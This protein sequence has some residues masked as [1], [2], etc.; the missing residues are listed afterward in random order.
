MND[1]SKRFDTWL[2][3]SLADSE[4]GGG[5]WTIARSIQKL[6]LDGKP[7]PVAG[8]AA[9]TGRSVEEVEQALE[10]M[11]SVEREPDGTVVGFGLSLRPTPH[12][13]IL[14]NGTVLYAYCA[15]DTL[16]FPPMFGHTAIVESTCPTTGETIRMTVSPDGVSNVEPAAAVVSQAMPSDATNVRESVCKLGHFYASSEAAKPWREAHPDGVIV[17]VAK[18]FK[19]GGA[20]VTTLEKHETSSNRR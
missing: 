5:A 14:D 16:A 2:S 4:V 9:E 6:L 12:R 15:M 18:G 19:L 8:L 20:I 10:A 7:V 11:P 13:Y 3:T 1:I 17:P